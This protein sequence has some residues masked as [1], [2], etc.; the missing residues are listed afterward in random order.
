MEK[1]CLVMH[2]GSPAIEV[3]GQI[4]PPM[5]VTLLHHDEEYYQNLRKAGVRIFFLTCGT[6]WCVK[7]ALEELQEN[8]KKL[9]DAVPDALCFLRITIDPPISWM[10]EHPEELMQYEDGSYEPIVYYT[11]YI[12]A[13]TVPGQPF[14]GSQR[15]REEGGRY[16]TDFLDQLD[17]TPLR[18][19]IIGYFLAAGSTSEWHCRGELNHYSKNKGAGFSPSERKA[20]SGYLREKYKTEEALRK[21]WRDPTAT[22]ADPHIPP[23]DERFFI[24]ID[25]LAMD[26]YEELT[27]KKGADNPGNEKNIGSF[28]NVD[29]YMCVMDFFRSF[30]QVTAD[31]VVYFAELLKKRDDSKMVGAF[32]SGFACT[33]FFNNGSAGGTLKILDSC[34]DYLATPGMYDE[35]QPGGVTAL[36][37]MQD[38]F[39]LRGKVFIAE[40]DTRTHRDDP[41]ERDRMRLYT[42]EDTESVMKRD[43][44]RDICEDIYGWWFDHSRVGVRYKEQGIYDLIARQ[45]EVAKFAYTLDRRKH[46]QVALLFDE[47]SISLVTQ[48]T[49]KE[50]CDLFRTSEIHRI[51]LPVDYYFHNDLARDDMPDYQVYVFV[52]CFYLTDE[53]RRA[54]EEKVRKKG[55]MAIWIYAS[56]F[57]NPDADARM[58]ADNITA[59]TGIHTVMDP[60][61]TF[62][63]FKVNTDHPSMAGIDP[64]RIYGNFDRP[65]RSNVWLRDTNNVTYAY[66]LFYTDDP[67]ATVL[68]RFCN[69]GLPALTIK[70]TDGFYSV[71]CGA[72][73]LRAD[74][75]Q[76]LARYAGC[77]VW[78]DDTDDV[79]Y[80]NQNF[81]VMHAASSGEKTLHLPRPC[82]VFEVYE[83]KWYGKQVTDLTIPMHFGETKMFSLAG[84]C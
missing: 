77:H 1:A 10:E 45:Q 2:N 18:D 66:P 5:T 67:D 20:F 72:K 60:T 15:W 39:R 11:Q 47:E 22:F 17:Q 37:S 84:E 16:L 53:E 75:I 62:T 68:G 38:S 32:Y 34:V 54:I 19:H 41:Q 21:A 30:H 26:S 40:D 43:F 36:R 24:Q 76:A 46:N 25:R 80:A 65:I 58:S 74:L 13:E 59:L 57:I 82:D 3:D 73:I 78:A 49:S 63:N 83:K 27:H 9:L 55:K 64:Y 69:N 42:L 35:R 52:N 14:L 44:G 7:G 56:G 28:L 33:H 70:E 29:K 23:M 79:L 48:Q 71:F 51:G 61:C 81:V 4:F 31:S 12:H 6:E 50:L 8:A